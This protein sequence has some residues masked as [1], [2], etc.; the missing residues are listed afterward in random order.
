M[1]IKNAHIVRKI[2][3]PSLARRMDARISCCYQRAMNLIYFW[4]FTGNL[5]TA[6][7]LSRDTVPR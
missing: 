3:R 2:N 7:R 4:R 6:I 5:R 1:P